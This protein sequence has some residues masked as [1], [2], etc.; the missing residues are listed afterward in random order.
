MIKPGDLVKIKDIGPL[1]LV[2]RSGIGKMYLELDGEKFWCP[3][4]ILRAAP[5][6]KRGGK[7]D[8][9]G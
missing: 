7:R 9:I 5:T 2:L 3:S 8:G 4:G 6:G 1:A